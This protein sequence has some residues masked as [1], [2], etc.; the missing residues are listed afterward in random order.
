[1]FQQ[2]S[3]QFSTLPE[4]RLEAAVRARPPPDGG[5]WKQP[6][7]VY[8]KATGGDVGLVLALDVFDEVIEAEVTALIAM[9]R[10]STR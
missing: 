9:V 10:K 6:P 8:P 3:A 5:S 4:V 1:M 7:Y 2:N